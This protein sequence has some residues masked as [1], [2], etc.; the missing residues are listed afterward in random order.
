[1]KTLLWVMVGVAVF[2][3]GIQLGRKWWHRAGAQE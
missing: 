1:L 2:L 3:G